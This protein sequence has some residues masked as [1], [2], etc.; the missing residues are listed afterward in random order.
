MITRSRSRRHVF[1]VLG[2]MSLL[3]AM[4]IVALWL[5]ERESPG[6][7]R[8]PPGSTRPERVLT[9]AE[10]IEYASAQYELTRPPVAASAITMTYL[11]FMQIGREDP[12]DLPPTPAVKDALLTYPEYDDVVWVVALRLDDTTLDE[13]SYGTPHPD[14]DGVWALYRY[15]DT[16]G[17]KSG[18]LSRV[19][20]GYTYDM[21]SDRP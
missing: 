6:P 16:R 1:T 10:V 12:L 3:A 19:P 9:A 4:A 11:Q 7:A 18:L 13:G 8:R 5:S 2:I 14:W 17:A 15:T 21:L 20:P